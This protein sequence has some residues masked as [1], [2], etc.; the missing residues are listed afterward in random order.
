M[1][2]KTMIVHQIVKAKGNTTITL[3]DLDKDG[4]TIKSAVT[5]IEQFERN[6]VS[7]FETDEVYEIQ[8]VRQ[9]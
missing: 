6:T 5:L 8:F 2:T 3:V 4:K 7:E 9:T 1:V